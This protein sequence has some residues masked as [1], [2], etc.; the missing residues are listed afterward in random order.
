ML[1]AFKQS[2]AQDCEWRAADATFTAT[3]PD[4]AGPAT[5]I[6][7]LNSRYV[8]GAQTFLILMYCQLAL[9]TSLLY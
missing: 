8:P 6:A 2:N 1:I 5:G 7:T 9:V 3:D 4:G